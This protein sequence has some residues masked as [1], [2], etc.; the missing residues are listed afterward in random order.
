MV[1]AQAK[2]SIRTQLLHLSLVIVVVSIAL[3]L[4]GTL[5]FSLRSEQAA[6]DNNLL[7]S[8]SILSQVPLLQEAL[9]GK[10]PLDK[11]ADY[12]DDTIRH[13]SDIDLILVGDTDSTLFY[14]PDRTLIGTS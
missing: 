11:L 5:Y 4:V 3:S 14:V 12:L 2:P 10:L 13:T 6:L 8:A 1:Q 9:Q 7:N